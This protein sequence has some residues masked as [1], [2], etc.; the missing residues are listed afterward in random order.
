MKKRII[1][2]GIGI[3]II[4][5]SLYFISAN[6]LFIDN[7]YRSSFSCVDKDYDG[8]CDDIDKCPNSI[9]GQT[10]DTMG[11]DIFQF[12]K[13]FYC[14]SRCFYADF[15]NDEPLIEYPDDCTIIIKNIEGKYY[16]DCVP[17]I[18]QKD[19]LLNLTDQTV[20]MRVN[21]SGLNSFFDVNLSNVPAGYAITNGIY[22]GWCVN[23]NIGITLSKLYNVKMYS[24]YD[25]FLAV[26]CP[27]CYTDH[28]DQINYI[29]NNKQGNSTDIQAAI[30]HIMDGGN[31]PLT[32][33]AKLMVQNS[34]IYGLGFK[35]SKGQLMAVLLVSNN[36]TQQTF[37]ETDP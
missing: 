31:Y 29:L 26:K 37:I 13:S 34:S 6:N 5:L 20:G 18:C 23:W 36:R 30:W 32:N 16:P 8:V 14:S 35:P 19:V 15:R 4:I 9:V 1:T 3:L 22:P 17:L 33:Y 7:F 12:C 28:W 25:P 11:C 27:F 21:N 24:S 10:V 2:S